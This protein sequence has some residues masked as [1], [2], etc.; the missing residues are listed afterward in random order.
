[1]MSWTPAICAAFRMASELACSSKRQ[2]F[3]ATVPSDMPAEILV[4]PLIERCAVKPYGAA[5][6]RPDSNQRLRERGLARRARAE[7]RQSRAG[8]ERKRDTGHDRHIEA[9]GGHRKILYG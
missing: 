3:S 2:M 8:L 5:M 7:Q 4:A 6:R 9:R 1:M